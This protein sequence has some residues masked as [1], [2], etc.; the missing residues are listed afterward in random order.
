[1]NETQG[2]TFPTDRLWPLDCHRSRMLTRLV[3][4]L[5][6]LAV[7]NAAALVPLPAPNLSLPVP[8]LELNKG[9]ANPEILFLARGISSSA[10]TAQSI[11][12]SPLGVQQNF[13][14]SNP[15][16]TLRL[17]DPLSGVANSFTG[18]DPSKWVTGIPRYST[19]LLSGIYPGVD[20]QYL[21]GSGGQLTLRLILQPAA[22]SGQIVF[23]IPT[24]F[25]PN[26]TP[27]GTLIIYLT[28]SRQYGPSLVYPPP[29]ATEQSASGPANISA[30]FK[31]LST[32][33]FGLQVN[34][35]SGSGVV[36]IDLQLGSVGGFSSQGV[37]YAT[38][39]TAN[40]FGAAIVADAAGKDDPFPSVNGVGCGDETGYPMPCED[41]AVYKFS[42]AGDLIFVTYLAGR[43]T[44]AANF[45][46]LAPDG[47][48][49]VTGTTDSSDFPVTAGA[50]QTAYAGPPA[51]SDLNP[52]FT[53]D[54]FASRLD[55]STGALLQ[56]TYLGGPNSDAPGATAIGTDGS[57]YFI[58]KFVGAFSAAMP[59]TPGA[60]QPACS[61]EPCVNGYAAHLSPS[62]D[63][64]LYGTYLPGTAQA[65]AQLSSDGSVYYAGSAN[66][67]FPTTP[68]AYQSKPAGGYDGIVARLD[69]SG[70]KLLFA[71]YIGGPTTDWILLLAAAGDGSVWIRLDSFVDCCLNIGYRL[72]HLDANGQKILADLPVGTD[73][74]YVDPAGNLIAM[75]EGSFKPSPNALV[76]S[77]CGSFPYAY[78]RL[79]PT[80]QQLFATYLPYN[81]AITGL[82]SRGLPILQF[83]GQ[84]YEIDESQPNGVFA[85][86]VL[87]AASFANGDVVFP[88]EIVTL[89]GSGLGPQQGVAFQL[90][91]GN[92]PST[93]GGTSVLINGQPVPLLY[94]SYGQVNA[95]VPYS[96]PTGSPPTIQVEV[97]G[98]VG[99][100]LAD[101]VDGE[102]LLA[103]FRSGGNFAAALNEDG[104]VNSP[105]NPAKPGSRV[106]LFATGGGQTNPPGTTGEV[107]PLEIRP[108]QNAIT[109]VIAGPN[110]PALSVE[111]AGAA[112]GLVAG[113]TQI[114]VKLPDTIPVV[115]GT[116]PGVLPLIVEGD[117]VS[118][119][120]STPTA[121]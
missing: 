28:E 11:L 27:N 25:L 119:A 56:S 109:V 112:P 57:L 32:T 99:N 115:G 107:T 120:V 23:E 36:Q 77:S 12:F 6:S 3:S 17:S 47:T 121:Q 22:D 41:V 59:T 113:V 49:I 9:Q 76:T 104:S 26:A 13:V 117:D 105:V 114:N 64:L 87:D 85:G 118:I 73:S 111:Y 43:T 102:V 31:V 4:L 103:V 61:G 74:L 78:L 52:E 106:V 1:M 89:F 60:L 62:L 18:T 80:G 34:G 30:S 39:K 20:A 88:G 5:A 15:N 66:M 92:L 21:M 19:A 71:T 37:L 90:Q 45:L 83:A 70:S 84:N 110:N 58:P 48:V 44:E 93:L 53:G 75:A 72:V 82:S 55:P 96:L 68:G 100:Q 69:P 7:A 46:G 91:N 24:A 14:A 54:F 16:P 35:Q 101:R 38:D 65:T 79:S 108:L 81:P 94:S 63:K 67:D 33:R 8:G 42:K 98:T 50:F 97:K 95:I 2:T 51:D 29:V 116:P 40:T 10:F 86:C